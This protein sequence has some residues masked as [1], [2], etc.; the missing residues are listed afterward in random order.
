MDHFKQDQKLQL[1]R[2]TLFLPVTD[3][4]KAHSPVEFALPKARIAIIGAGVLGL[5]CARELIETGGQRVVLFDSRNAGELQRTEEAFSLRL[6]MKQLGLELSTMGGYSTAHLSFGCQTEGKN[7]TERQ[8]VSALDRFIVR[9]EHGIASLTDGCGS[10]SELQAMPASQFIRSLDLPKWAVSMLESRLVIAGEANRSTALSLLQRF[11]HQRSN[12][13]TGGEQDEPLKISPIRDYVEHLAST[14]PEGAAGY[15]HLNHTLTALRKKQRGFELQ[16]DTEGGAVFHYADYI[17]LAAPASELTRSDLTLSGL[18]DARLRTLAALEGEPEVRAVIIAEGP[19]HPESGFTTVLIEDIHGL[20]AD[21]WSSYRNGGRAVEGTIRTIHLSEH[22]V[23][24]HSALYLD[25]A[26]LAL[27][28]EDHNPAAPQGQLV[29]AAILGNMLKR[30]E[31][32]HPAGQFAS[33]LH[34]RKV[35]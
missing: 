15:L 12:E 6:L 7:L 5:T 24:P 17:V 26:P 28:N 19:P 25:E 35:A 8:F 14:S 22:D 10:F 32:F 31:E 11:A 34:T 29:A 20:E 30:R 16:F 13:I 4:T 23:A 33:F 1:E 18:T 9:V 21:L 2:R 3:E 27:N